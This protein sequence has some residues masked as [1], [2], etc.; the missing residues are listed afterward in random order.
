MGWI[1]WNL[2]YS[3]NFQEYLTST[4]FINICCKHNNTFLAISRKRHSMNS[5]YFGVSKNCH[6]L[7]HKN[8]D[9]SLSWN[10]LSRKSKTHFLEIFHTFSERSLK[11]LSSILL[12]LPYHQKEQSDKIQWGSSLK[13]D[14]QQNWKNIST[15]S[16]VSSSGKEAM[17]L[18]FL[19]LS[20]NTATALV[21]KTFKQM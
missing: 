9:Y 17:Y 2:N 21:I 3:Q 6:P 8:S 5:N 7:V 20:N 15:M 1:D 13:L 10:S 4:S 16:M 12:C 14:A 19:I 11:K 18:T